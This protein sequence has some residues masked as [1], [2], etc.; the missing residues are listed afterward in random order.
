VMIGDELFFKAKVTIDPTK[1]PKTIDYEMKEGVN[2][3]K[4]QL[5]IYE[6]EGD[7]FRSC[8]AAPGAD[9]PKE[10]KGG[11]KLT[12]SEWKPKKEA[13]EGEKAK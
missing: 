5:G 9:R 8:F 10:F 12:L 3:G 13:A 1:T 6:F 7:K 11:E 4:T 2:A